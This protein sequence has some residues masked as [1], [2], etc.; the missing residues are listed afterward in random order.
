MRLFVFLNVKKAVQWLE[1]VFSVVTTRLYHRF[2]NFL[3]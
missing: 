2:V 1:T 3:Q